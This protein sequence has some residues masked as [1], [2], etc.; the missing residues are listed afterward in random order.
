[1]CS[2]SDSEATYCSEVE[3]LIKVSSAIKSFAPQPLR[4]SQRI[5]N[6]SK[7]Q[8]IDLND[9]C[10]CD[11]NSCIDKVNNKKKGKCSNKI[12]LQ[13]K[14]T[15][16]FLLTE[17]L[18]QVHPT[19]ICE[20]NGTLWDKRLQ[21]QHD[22]PLDLSKKSKESI[23]ETFK[24][25]IHD[26]LTS[27]KEESYVVENN[28][29]EEPSI[30]GLKLKPTQE[31]NRIELKENTICKNK[32][33]S[34]KN[35]KTKDKIIAKINNGNC[36]PETVCLKEFKELKG[37]LNKITEANGVRITDLENTG[38]KTEINTTSS[39]P[40]S[41]D[42]QTI[43]DT[44]LKSN[45]VHSSNNCRSKESTKK[46]ISSK[47]F[48]H[49]TEKEQQIKRC[50][51]RT[52]I[53]KENLP[54][55]VIK[56]DD[57]KAE[58]PKTNLSFRKNSNDK[59]SNAISNTDTK[60]ADVKKITKTNKKSKRN[61]FK[62]KLSTLKMKAF[63][64]PIWPNT[65]TRRNKANSL[66]KHY[67]L[68]DS[69]KN[70]RKT[71]LK[72]NSEEIL[73][74]TKNCG[75]HRPNRRLSLPENATMPIKQDKRKLKIPETDQPLRRPLPSTKFFKKFANSQNLL[76][77]IQS[78]Q[79][80]MSKFMLVNDC[81]PHFKQQLQTDIGLSRP[82]TSLPTSVITPDNTPSV[83]LLDSLSSSP[84][85]PDSL[86]ELLQTKDIKE[87]LNVDKVAYRIYDYH[88]QPLALI[89]NQ[90]QQYLRQ[91]LDKVVSIQSNVLKNVNKAVEEPFA[92]DKDL[93]ANSSDEEV[94][95]NN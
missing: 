1:M 62:T 73:S 56:I 70:Y 25:G 75:I 37:S 66:E 94:G 64:K 18:G 65:N 4:R 54:A 59:T 23:K 71:V 95:N 76:T 16:E 57:L 77:P 17:D 87:L 3:D 34:R 83:E 26:S 53:L 28:I 7:K 13:T 43:V 72:M 47:N 19:F 81:P 82:F 8:S 93:F 61:P 21:L 78:T 85:L 5:L 90:S 63:K 52:S 41:D 79:D 69:K 92:K 35:F 60:S 27:L 24:E 68:K 55:K 42:L 38:L 80:L 32:K 20:Q 48:A 10:F 74:K 12:G 30:L 45:E 49:S 22:V 58:L 86:C 11:L 91:A 31:V 50:N 33:R 40:K 29:P 46:F 36:L 9:F 67:E 44:S 39:K 51:K 14:A 84:S 6:K 2:K 89:L 15:Q 88:I